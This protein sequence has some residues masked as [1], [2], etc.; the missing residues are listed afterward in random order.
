MGLNVFKLHWR[1]R[2]EEAN[3]EC[4]A[5]VVN[6]FVCTDVGFKQTRAHMRL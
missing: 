3:I 1:V 2:T 4:L 5:A 6:T